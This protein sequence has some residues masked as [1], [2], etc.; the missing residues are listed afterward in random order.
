MTQPSRRFR[1][2][3]IALTVMAV[4]AAGCTSDDDDVSTGGGGGDAAETIRLGVA[5][6]DIEAFARINK[7][8][9][10]GD[11]EAQINAPFDAWRDQGILPINGRD[12]ELVVRRYNILNADDKLAVCRAFAQDDEVFAVVAGRSFSEGSTCLAERFQIPVIDTDG[13][14]RSD[15]ERGAPYLF[16]VRPG[17]NENFVALARWASEN[18]FLDGAVGLFWESRL[19]EAVNDL[20]AELSALDVDLASEISASGEGIG[21]PQDKVAMQKFQAD[22]VEVALPLVGGSSMIAILTFAEDQGYRPQYLSTDY[23]TH[24]ADVATGPYPA[25]QFEGMHA[26][27]VFR[28]GEIAADMELTDATTECLDNYEAFTGETVERSFPETGVWTNI[29]LMCDLAS[30]V[31]AGMENAGDELTKESFV[32]GLEAIDGLELAGH[33]NVTY[34]PDDRGG[35]DEFR[36]VQWSGDCKCW[37][38]QGDFRRYE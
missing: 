14:V 7:A 6:P 37:I 11:Q 20:K 18:G 13:V 8:F 10:V 17:L 27:T 16:T 2:A 33:G 28:V 25:E 38:A 1:G 32:A 24:T 12:V 29:L 30:I 26:I 22:G 31:R 4:V 35:V 5:I 21:T 3:V 9:D 19:E 36:T 15:Y 23:G 34:G